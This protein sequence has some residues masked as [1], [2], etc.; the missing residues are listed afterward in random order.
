MLMTTGD[1]KWAEGGA[2]KILLQT[3]GS[4]LVAE[5]G[6]G[7]GLNASLG[8][9]AN[10][11]A[12]GKIQEFAHELA[13]SLGNNPGGQ[14]LFSNLITNI[15]AGAVG[16]LAG[17][18][19]GANAASNMD[20]NNRQLHKEELA[21]LIALADGDEE[22]LGRL[23]AV[24]CAKVKCEAEFEVDSPLYNYYKN[25][26]DQAADYLEEWE[27]LANQRIFRPNFG[28]IR[29]MYGPGE[30]ADLFEYSSADAASDYVKRQDNTYQLAVRAQGLGQMIIS[31]LVIVGAASATMASDGALSFITV[32]AILLNVDQAMAGANQFVNGV[33]TE[34]N[35]HQFIG[36]LGLSNDESS[37]LENALVT[38][39]T[40]G[41][42]KALQPKY[43]P[44]IEYPPHD[45]FLNGVRKTTILPEGTLIDRY[46][47]N[48]G[49]YFSPV[50]TSF[51]SRALPA[52]SYGEP[53]N[54]YK[55]IQP[56]PVQE[57]ITAPWYNQP[58]L[59]TQFKTER[60]AQWL[61][62][63]DFIKKLTK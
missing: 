16:Y 21:R 43:N 60:S 38:A 32:A 39:G 13:E 63:H 51:P 8:A 59:G 6:N 61:I 46:G 45:G 28:A 7:E 48:G 5:I 52:E 1:E 15:A 11:L 55:V 58:G 47:S 22:K 20:R 40:V 34:T 2:Y 56:L 12:T 53:Y 4:A 36:S 62:D 41:V 3:V 9:V 18:E 49:R 37:L 33:P 57:G 42:L 29:M 35:L 30:Y 44:I 14:E 26:V 31:E 27:L 25:L 23:L 24:A 17:D 50:G 10:Q 54:V 19:T